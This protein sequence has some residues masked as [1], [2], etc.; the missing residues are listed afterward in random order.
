VLVVRDCVCVCMWVRADECVFECVRVWVC[1]RVLYVCVS[2]P[3]RV[4]SV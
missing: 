4:I 2:V 3:A 1:V